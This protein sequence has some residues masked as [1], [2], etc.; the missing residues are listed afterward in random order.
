MRSY[1]ES[2]GCSG[3]P[4]LFVCTCYFGFLPSQKRCTAAFNAFNAVLLFVKVHLCFPQFSEPNL[5]ISL[6]TVPDFI[7][8][9]SRHQQE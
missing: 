5:K 3:F 7:H 2:L 6:V 1:F 8:V 4:C 9:V